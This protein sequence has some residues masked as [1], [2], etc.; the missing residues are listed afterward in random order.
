MRPLIEIRKWVKILNKKK[1]ESI[2]PKRMGTFNLSRN[3][4]Y[5]RHTGEEYPQLNIETEK[6]LVKFLRDNFGYGFYTVS[7][8]LKGR[9]G[10]FVFWKGEVEPDY[11]CFISESK[12]DFTDKKQIDN[13]DRQINEVQ[14]Q[15]EAQLLEEMKEDIKKNA[16]SKKG[17]RYGFQPYLKSS[18]R[19]GECHYWTD[20]DLA[21]ENIT[22][23]NS[24]KSYETQIPEDIDIK[25]NK[26]NKKD[27]EK[28]SL[29]DI[30]D[31]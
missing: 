13:I 18:G 3:K 22:S 8:Y 9:R 10:S 4:R 14:D 27:F 29:D 20:P 1:E 21:K 24:N 11:W 16:T 7:A 5:H 23:N 25:E 19:R 6:E 30:N 15:D 28:M 12:Y 2:F 26:K 17:K 31:F